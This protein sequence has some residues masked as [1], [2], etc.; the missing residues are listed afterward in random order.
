MPLRNITIEVATRPNTEQ[1]LPEKARR[2]AN[3]IWTT[4]PGPRILANAQNKHPNH[5]AFVSV[6]WS[7]PKEKAKGF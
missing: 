2:L 1:M 6:Q 4:E 3:T 7:F 5:M